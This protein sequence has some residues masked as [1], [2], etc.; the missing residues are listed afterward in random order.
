MNRRKNRFNNEENKINIIVLA[1]I[2]FIIVGAFIL[3]YILYSNSLRKNT[4]SDTGDG[5][6]I[7]SR[8]ETTNSINLLSVYENSAEASSSMG[9]TVNE[10]E[11]NTK[12]AVNT[13]IVE[14]TES[15]S[16]ETATENVVQS[17]ET[18]NEEEETSEDVKEE[19]E[20]VEENPEEPAE[21]GTEENKVVSFTFP[22]NGEIIKDYAKENL[23][24]S[25]T[26]EEWTTHLGIDF[27]AEKTEVVKASADGVIKSIKND[28]RYG[29]TIVIEHA[30]GF[31]SIYSSLLSSEFVTVGEEVK[32]GQT[33]ATVGNTATFE[34]ADDTH[35]HFEIKE[36]GK[37]V[38]PNI[39]LK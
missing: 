26:L 31:E 15:N 27:A 5:E 13:S 12:V 28:P 38:D 21:E 35:L 33:I 16:I 25:N 20:T 39:Y 17:E 10:L 29:L 3:S 4:E 1:S 7:A 6:Q 34:I 2:V 24:Y 18:T 8:N 9:R 36:N 32:Q 11:N 30:N 14:N 19:E 37:N 23:I 22:V